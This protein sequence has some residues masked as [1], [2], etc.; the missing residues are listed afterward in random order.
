M[1]KHSLHLMLDSLHAQRSAVSGG[2]NTGCAQRPM[3]LVFCPISS[4]LCH[5]GIS[6]RNIPCTQPRGSSIATCRSFS[7]SP[8]SSYLSRR[9]SLPTMVT[10]RSY[11]LYN[12]FIVFGMTIFAFTTLCCPLPRFVTVSL[13]SANFQFLVH[14]AYVNGHHVLRSRS[15]GVPYQT[16]RCG[17]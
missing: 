3:Y 10:C 17:S 6:H 2:S 5:I 13:T 8:Y 7:Y 12:V 14:V 4:P 11:K 15:S 1:R 16:S 9:S